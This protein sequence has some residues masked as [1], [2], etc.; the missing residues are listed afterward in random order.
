MGVDFVLPLRIFFCT[1]SNK[2]ATEQTTHKYSSWPLG[3]TGTGNNK[4]TFN[5]SVL[6]ASHIVP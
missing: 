1:N 2:K 4:A 6:Q 5:T 3:R